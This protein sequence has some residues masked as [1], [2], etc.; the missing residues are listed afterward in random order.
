MLFSTSSVTEAE[1][2]EAESGGMVPEGKRRFAIESARHS[3]NKAG[4]GEYI[5][6]VCVADGMNRKVWLYFNFKHSNP[7]VEKLGRVELK[8]FLDALGISNLTSTDILHGRTFFAIVKHEKDK[9][10]DLRERLHTY[11]AD[12]DVSF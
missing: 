2:K 6:V 3:Q 10:G 7:T 12:E 1:I 8:K 9:Q 5:E 11:G 4:T